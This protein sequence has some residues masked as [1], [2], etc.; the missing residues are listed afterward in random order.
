MTVFSLSPC[1]P[2]FGRVL[3]MRRLI[4]SA[5]TVAVFAIP[6]TFLLF[7]MRHWFEFNVPEPK[8]TAVTVGIVMIV[9]ALIIVRDQRLKMAPDSWKRVKES[10]SGA[11]AVSGGLLVGSTIFG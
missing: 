3:L 11:I 6:Y 7:A 5:L 8:L 2:A 1:L 4:T 10:L 9:T